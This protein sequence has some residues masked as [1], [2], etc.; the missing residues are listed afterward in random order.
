MDKNA[1]ESLGKSSRRSAI[2]SLAGIII[3]MGSFVYSSWEL[4]RTSDLLSN[5]KKKFDDD[6]AKDYKLRIKDSLLRIDSIGLINQTNNLRSKI[7]A[8]LNTKKLDEQNQRPT[9]NTYTLAQNSLI[10]LTIYG[11]NV[12]T[13][14]FNNVNQ[15]LAKKG[16]T[17]AQ[18][19]VLGVRLKWLA[20]KPT[21][22]YYDDSMKATA[23]NIANELSFVT[24]QKFVYTRGNAHNVTPGQASYTV[25]IDYVL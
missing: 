11:F 20:Y 12:D 17:I 16:Y 5:M 4:S 23:E 3:F 6:Q 10:S 1:L 13:N 25:V 24:E 15:Y 2:I 7:Q 19:A 8:L 21:V 22:V 14:T 18:S 9:H